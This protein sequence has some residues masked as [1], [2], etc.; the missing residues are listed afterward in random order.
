MIKVSYDTKKFQFKEIL[1]NLLN[2]V[3]LCQ[4]NETMKV[5][6]RENDQSTVYHKMYYDWARTDEFV[7]LYQNFIREVVLPIYNKSIVYQSIPTFRVAFQ[8]NIAVGEFHKDKWY[9]DISWA[10][11]VS[12]DNFFLPF[13]DAF[14]T[15]TIWVE[16][17][18]DKGDYFPMECKYGEI[19][20]W[21][22]SNLTHGNKINTTGKTRISVDFR[23]IPYDRYEPSNHGSINMDSKFSIGGYYD[24]LEI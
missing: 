13:T 21:N 16:T 5:L 11:K 8:N 1:S 24:L 22:G 15:N 19:I 3:D 12:E 20:K 17:E 4:I 9:R 6:K 10:E 2:T 23:V 18:E 7:N 14:D